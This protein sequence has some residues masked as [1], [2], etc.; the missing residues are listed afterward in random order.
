[1]SI[2]LFTSS[3]S[4]AR[5]AY[6]SLQGSVFTSLA[7]PVSIMCETRSVSS[8]S[9]SERANTYNCH[10][11]ES[12]TFVPFGLFLEM[13]TPLQFA[14]ALLIVCSSQFHF[15]SDTVVLLYLILPTL[16]H[17]PTTGTTTATTAGTT[18]AGTTTA[19]T[20][21]AGSTDPTCW[22]LVK[23]TDLFPQLL[24]VCNSKPC[25][26]GTQNILKIAQNISHS[27]AGCYRT[28]VISTV[29]GCSIYFN[30]L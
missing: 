26:A 6:G 8:S 24:S 17:S 22:P 15:W 11:I 14:I 9:S 28:Y 21:T 25:T 3:S 5:N 20:T 18:T 10:R 4:S 7:S 23:V 16:G 13:S 29:H 1:M 19:G 12:I 2:N 27:L 30:C